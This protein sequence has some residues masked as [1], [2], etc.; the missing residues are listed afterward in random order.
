MRKNRIPIIFLIFAMCTTAGFADRAHEIAK[1]AGLFVR[2]TKQNAASQKNASSSA[3]PAPAI[4]D[5][6]YL[7]FLKKQSSL[8]DLEPERFL[9]A[10]DFKILNA[11]VP[12]GMNAKNH[13]DFAEFLADRGEGNIYGIVGYLY[14][15]SSTPASP[16]VALSCGHG[17]VE[18]TTDFHMGIG[19][20]E[21]IAKE[22]RSSSSPYQNDLA[23][24]SIVVEMTSMFSAACSPP[25]DFQMLT[26]MIGHPVK[27]V[28]QLILDN[29]DLPKPPG[30][31]EVR[32]V[33][34]SPPFSYWKIIPVTRF[35]VS[36]S[37]VICA[38]DSPDWKKIEEIMKE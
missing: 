13:T 38:P 24:K 9:T 36:K 32:F 23:Q 21:A 1:T 18:A 31:F 17:Y 10:D 16:A 35:Y 3:T 26:A 25:W 37:D 28:G 7:G 5:D 2:L 19:F 8:P 27:A 30:A 22:I 14:Y 15:V 20:D 6:L 4:P 29:G 11:T 12:A 34:V 33:P